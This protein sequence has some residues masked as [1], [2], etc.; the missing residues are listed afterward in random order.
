[1]HPCISPTAVAIG[2]PLKAFISNQK[3]AN[4][5]KSSPDIPGPIWSLSLRENDVWVCHRSGAG[6]IS[7]GQFHS[8]IDETGVWNIWPSSDPNIWYAG[9][10]RGLIQIKYAPRGRHPKSRWQSLGAMVGF[11]ESSRFLREESPGIWWVSHP[12]KGA[13][14]LELDE[15]NRQRIKHQNLRCVSRLS[16]STANQHVQPRYAYG[17][18]Y[19]KGFLSMGCSN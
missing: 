10:Y 16:R 6:V 4:N 18:C 19:F 11:E 1:M 5:W 17:L 12:Y 3:A 7:D 13:F 15:L 9:T 14:R 2:E 8:I